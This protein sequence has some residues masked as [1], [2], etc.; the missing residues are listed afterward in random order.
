LF[1]SRRRQEVIILSRAPRPTLGSHSLLLH[2]AG[3]LSSDLKRPECGAHPS[4]LPKAELK[5]EWGY[6]SMS[7]YAC[8]EWCSIRYRDDFHLFLNEN[9]NIMTDILFFILD[10]IKSGIRSSE[11]DHKR[12]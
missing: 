1:D 12:K 6:T 10:L 7:I 8:M 2:V 11:L 4:A 9:I 5:S 3:S